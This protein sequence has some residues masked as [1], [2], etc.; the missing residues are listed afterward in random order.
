MQMIQQAAALSS[1]QS[2]PESITTRQFEL[3]KCKGVSFTKV[4][5]C[6]AM[7]TSCVSK[8]PPVTISMPMGIFEIE[9][10]FINS[11]P[12]LSLFQLDP[13]KMDRVELAF[14]KFDTNNDG[15]LS[16]DEFDVVMYSRDYYV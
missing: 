4:W 10:V 3:H 2:V 13:S 6:V 12:L 5:L 14:R 7:G 1:A 16:R 11:R 15:Y 8:V 9:E